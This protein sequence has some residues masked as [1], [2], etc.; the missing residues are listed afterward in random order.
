V[1]LSSK[2][3]YLERYAEA[4]KGWTDRDEDRWPVPYWH[5]DTAMASLLLLLTAVD[6]G[7]GAC[8]FGVEPDRVGALRKAFGV[9]AEFTPVGAVT[10]GHRTDDPGVTGS[11]R[12]GRKPLE[13]VVHRG[14]WGSAAP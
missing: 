10:V 5:L 3:A 12:R 14:R 4:D 1:P 11:A 13:E 7:L 6:E 2:Q 8:F 9:P